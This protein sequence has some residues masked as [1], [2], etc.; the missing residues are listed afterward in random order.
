MKKLLSGAQFSRWLRWIE[1][2]PN[3]CWIWRGA[4]TGSGYGQLQ[5]KSPFSWDP[6]T[7]AHRFSYE[8]YTSK[9]LGDLSVDHLCRN[10]L[11]VNPK[12]L[13]AVT[14]S[15]NSSRAGRGR[16]DKACK[17]GHVRTVANTYNWR[18]QKRCRICNARNAFVAYRRLVGK[19]FDEPR[20]RKAKW[21]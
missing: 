6:P 1:R 8:L 4:R 17:A 15:E 11:C 20:T 16:W 21:E 19:S 18:G 13:E 14:R 5:I 9:I 2:Y 3:G 7:L 12:H 10:K